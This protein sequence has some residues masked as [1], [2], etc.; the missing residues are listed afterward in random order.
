MD[1]NLNNG[2]LF[3]NGKQVDIVFFKDGTTLRFP[4]AV[5]DEL[6]IT[7]GETTVSASGNGNTVY[8]SKNV[9]HPGSNINCGG[10]FRLG[11]G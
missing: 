10:D 7:A 5:D 9:I 2:D 4:T 1:L 3:L 8:N 11:D 6:K